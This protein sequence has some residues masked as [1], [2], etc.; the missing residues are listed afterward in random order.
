[1]VDGAFC[2]TKA[3]QHEL[4]Q[5]W[6][7]RLGNSICSAMGNAKCI[8]VEEVWEDMNITV[9]AS[10]IDG[11]V[12]L[13]SNRPALFKYDKGNK[14]LAHI[15]R[16]PDEDFSIL[17]EAVLM[18]DRRVAAALGEDVSTDEE[19]LWI[20]IKNGKQFVYPRLLFIIT[21]K[22]PDRKKYEDQ[23][24]R[25]KLRRV[26]LR[27]MWL[28]SEDYPLLLGMLANFTS[29]CTLVAQNLPNLMGTRA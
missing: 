22:G 9:F 13:K 12:F 15:F 25:L 2:V 23:I 10:K 28:A 1:M 3:M 6:G 19:Q 27:T 18:Y 5:N 8:S 11:E 29:V 17:L 16:T 4:A 7:I 26:A 20:D 14:P 24:K 21:G